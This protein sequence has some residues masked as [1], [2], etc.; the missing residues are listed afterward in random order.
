MQARVV[1][2]HNDLVFLSALTRSLRKAG[3]DVLDFTDPGAALTAL[4]SAGSIEVLIVRIGFDGFQGLG[5]PLARVAMKKHP[6]VKVIFVGRPEYRTVAMRIG[7]F[8]A[9]PAA[10]DDVVATVQQTLIWNPRFCS[11][12]VI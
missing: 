12:Y 1:A 4:V 5:L 11:G 3:H 8:I 10:V 7:T 6:E 9:A 2:I